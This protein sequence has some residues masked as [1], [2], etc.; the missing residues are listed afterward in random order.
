MITCLSRLGLVCLLMIVRVAYAA[1]FLAPEDAFK[2]RAA[3]QDTQIVVTISPEKNYYVYKESIRFE[4][5][6]SAQVELGQAVMPKAKMKFDENFGKT[7][8]IYPDEIQVK[9]PVQRAQSGIQLVMEL[10]GCAERGICY[11]PMKLSFTLAAPNTSAQGLY[12]DEYAQNQEQ[13]S[14]GLSDVWAA[15]DDT[16]VLAGL[17]ERV[18]LGA[19]LLAFFFLGLT[20][21]LTPCVLP[22]LPILSSIV[23]GAQAQAGSNRPKVKS[24]F[25]AL[26]YVLGMALMYSLVGVLTALVGSNLQAWIQHPLVL[27][28]FALI[29]LALAA[30]LFGLYELRMPQAWM[31]KINQIS[32]HQRGGRLM[33][34]FALGATATLIVS[35]C[36]TAP[37]AGVLAFIAQSGSAYLGA[38]LLFVM[39][40]GMGIPLLVIALGAKSLLPRAGAWMMYVQRLLGVMMVGLALWVVW[41]LLQVSQVPRETHALASGLVFDRVKTLEELDRQLAEAKNRRQKVMLDFYADW[42]ISCKEMEAL[43][44]A[45]PRVVKELKTYQLIQ[46]DVTKNTNEDRAILKRYQLFGPPAIIFY[47]QQGVEQ[48][49]QRVIGFLKPEKFLDRLPHN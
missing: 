28:A 14:V 24:L 27:S 4:A 45:D 39:A 25:L 5:Q 20:L 11:P 6:N 8:A 2:A 7:L 37:L 29:L 48:R 34:S 10:Q 40:W 31:D 18:P 3:W 30:S 1:D 17:L 23:L 32:G 49:D 41:P 26:S 35:P 21:S 15:R 43:T 47:D 44:L 16:G 9:V 22:M 12:I 36:V 46:V 38:S 42:C 13:K 19:L 33:G